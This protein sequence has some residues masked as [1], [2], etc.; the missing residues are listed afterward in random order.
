MAEKTQGPA[1]GSPQAPAPRKGRGKGGM[2][3]MEGVRQ[4]LGAVGNDAKPAAIQ[5]WLKENLHLEMP[6]DLIS[7][8]KSD[9]LAKARKG[10]KK[11][12]KRAAK[13]SPAPQAAPAPK[14]GRN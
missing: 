10:K 1:N 11:G 6:K 14:A 7:K 12:G 2:N 4:A 3:K 8:Y 13:P 9:I 5:D